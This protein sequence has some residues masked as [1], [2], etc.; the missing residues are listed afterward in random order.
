MIDALALLRTKPRA[1]L[2]FAAL[3]QSS[4]GTGAAYPALLVIA[5]ERFHSAWAISLVLLADFVPAMLLGP[6][7]GAVVD[8]WPRLWCGGAADVVRAVA[9][10]GIAV[11]GSFEATVSLALL[12]GVGT[13]LFRPAALSGIPDLVRSERVAA[14]TSLYGATSEFG[15]LAGGP[16]IAAVALALADPEELFVVNGATFA[17]SALVLFWLG[18]G[19][20]R[21][22]GDAQTEPGRSLLGLAREGLRATMQMPGVRVVILALTAGMFFGGV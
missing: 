15:T 13:A 19:E 9:F 21:R 2:F 6:V 22:T 3:G 17:V 18:R 4:L 5:Y 16:A 20:G 10:V 14:A 12:A 8:R 11:V 1:R 7:F